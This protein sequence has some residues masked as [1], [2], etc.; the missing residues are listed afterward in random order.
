MPF[1]FLL[2][3]R[4]Y[5]IYIRKP[6]LSIFTSDQKTILIGNFNTHSKRWG[7]QDLNAAGQDLEDIH[8][9]TPL[10]LIY[11]ASDPLTFLH[12]NGTCSTLDLLCVS[13]DKGTPTKREITEDPGSGHR[14]IVAHISINDPSSMAQNN[15]QK[16]S[17]NFKKAKGGKFTELLDLKLGEEKVNFDCYPDRLVRKINTAIIKCAKT[18]HP[19]SAKL[20]IKQTMLST[21]RDGLLSKIETKYG[22]NNCLLD[23]PYKPR[24]KAEAAFRLFTGHDCLAAHL[25]RNGILAEAA[26]PLCEKRNEP[27]DKYHLHTC[28]SLH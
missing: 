2:G 9:S 18:L 26:C 16:V 11:Q 19:W 23:I 17:W 24:W 1:I 10:E 15:Y 4:V 6:D 27:M 25:N 3:I 8:N 14:Q 5:A 13:S 22:R 20:F 12:F 21:Y 7:C 28:K